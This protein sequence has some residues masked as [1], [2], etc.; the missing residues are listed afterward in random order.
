MRTLFRSSR[1]LATLIPLAAAAA[2]TACGGGGGGGGGTP[3]PPAAAAVTITEANKIQVSQT[4]LNATLGVGA[5]GGALPLAADGDT[6]QA[7]GVATNH[8]GVRGQPLLLAS[9]VVTRALVGTAGTRRAQQARPQAAISETLPCAAGGSV[10]TTLNDNDNNQ[11]ATVGDSLVVSFA[12]CRETANDLTR[13]SMSI[14]LTAVGGTAPNLTFGATVTLT[15]LSFTSGNETQSTQGGFAMSSAVTSTGSNSTLT[16]GASGLTG[17]VTRPNYS[18]SYTLLQNTR[19]VVVVN[20]TAVPPGGGAAGST[21]LSFD[22]QVS[23]TRLGNQ[24]VTVA[25]PT[26]LFAYDVDAYP[27]SGQMIATGASNSR[28]RLTALSATTVRIELDANG[29]GSYESSVDQP[30]SSLF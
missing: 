4:T 8:R 21:T 28:V 20:D 12:D 25:T 6:A 15:N 26:P 7:A 30:W 5:A 11:Q 29:D 24:V 10:T 16:I 3:P 22:G 14:A 17:S 2:L 23:S 19:V 18:E 9:R 13:G 1:P 27:R